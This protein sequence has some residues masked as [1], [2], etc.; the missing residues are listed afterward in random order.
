MTKSHQTNISTTPRNNIQR[1]LGIPAIEQKNP[2][3]RSGFYGWKFLF[4]HLKDPGSFSHVRRCMFWFNSFAHKKGHSKV[5]RTPIPT[6]SHA[7][8]QNSPEITGQGTPSTLIPVPSSP[9]NEAE[10]TNAERPQEKVNKICHRFRWWRSKKVVR[11]GRK[12]SQGRRRWLRWSIE[13]GEGAEHQFAHACCSAI[14]HFSDRSKSNFGKR[15]INRRKLRN[16]QSS[17]TNKN[18]CLLL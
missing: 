9:P 8:E 2:E 5:Q 18:L 10:R 1:T 4:S 6:W 17:G 11:T 13:P 15:K 7:S 12:E 3:E 14:V 16:T